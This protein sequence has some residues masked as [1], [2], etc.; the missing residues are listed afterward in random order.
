LLKLTGTAVQSA[1]SGV[2]LFYVR[3]A[4]KVSTNFSTRESKSNI[5]PVSSFMLHMQ[6]ETGQERTHV[7]CY[8]ALVASN[9]SS[10]TNVSAQPAGDFRMIGVGD[11]GAFWVDEDQSRLTARRE[12][13]CSSG[14]LRPLMHAISNPS[15]PAHSKLEPRT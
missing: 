4:G 13:A 1:L 2:G 10:I 15:T 5:S 6:H 14:V 7:C 12:L 11:A 8:A 9:V 3:S